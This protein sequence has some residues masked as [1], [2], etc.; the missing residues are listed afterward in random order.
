MADIYLG[1]VSSQIYEFLASPRPCLFLNTHQVMWHD[2]Q[3]Y[4]HWRLGDV[5]PSAE[6]LAEALTTIEASPAR[7][8]KAQEEAFKETFGLNTKGSAH[9]AAAVLL[10]LARS[11]VN[12]T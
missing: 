9:R 11:A 4:A 2:D 3:N 1:D 6:R 12:A 7:Y 8:T 5:I 10:K